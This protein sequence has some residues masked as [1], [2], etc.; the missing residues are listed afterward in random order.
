MPI[1]Q[2]VLQLDVYAQRKGATCH[3]A[4][5][6]KLARVTVCADTVVLIHT[7]QGGTARIHT[8]QENLRAFQTFLQV[9]VPRLPSTA[10]LLLFDDIMLC[11]ELLLKYAT[12]ISIMQKQPHDDT[13]DDTHDTTP[14][15]NQHRSFRSAHKLLKTSPLLHSS[16]SIAQSISTMCVDLEDALWLLRDAILDLRARH[17]HGQ[18]PP[19]TTPAGLQPPPGLMQYAQHIAKYQAAAEKGDVSAALQLGLL[20]LFGMGIAADAAMAADWITKAAEAGLV[21]ALY[22]RGRLAEHGMHNNTGVPDMQ[23][24]SGCT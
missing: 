16:K 2:L 5:Q 20:L 14:S 13:H 21:D 12:L 15:T 10:F 18:S 1:T 9:E 23:V 6:H 17:P 24:M 22:W 7:P 19:T 11:Q 4:V 8:T 3:R